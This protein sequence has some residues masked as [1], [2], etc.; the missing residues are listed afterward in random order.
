MIEVTQSPN[1]DSRSMS[2]TSTEADLQ[3]ATESHIG[4]VTKGLNFMAKMIEARG[5]VHDHTKIGGIYNA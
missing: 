1:A 2:A 4:D 3:E 5:P